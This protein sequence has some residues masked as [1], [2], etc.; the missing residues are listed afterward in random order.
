[1]SLHHLSLCHSFSPTH[2]RTHTHTVSLSLTHTHTHAADTDDRHSFYKTKE[3]SSHNLSLSHTHTQTRTHKHTHTH[4]QLTRTTGTASTKHQQKRCPRYF[5]RLSELT[6]PNS[7]RLSIFFI[8]R[9]TNPTTI[10]SRQRCWKLRILCRFCFFL[11]K[12]GFN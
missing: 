8:G 4:T 12:G 9:G 3:I 7:Q 1:M 10:R 2:T 5:P 6:I 11:E